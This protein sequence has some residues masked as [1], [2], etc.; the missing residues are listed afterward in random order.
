MS[1]VEGVSAEQ[2]LR[3]VTLIEDTLRELPKYADPAAAIAAGYASIGDAGTGT[4]HYIKA[5]LIEDDVLLDPTAPE[6]LVYAVNGDQRTLAGA[7]YIASPRPADDP[8]LTDWAGPLMTWHKHDNL[9]WSAGDDGKA[10][11]VGVIDANGNCA[12]GVRVRRREPDGPRL[13]RTAPV[14]CLRRARR[15][16]CRHG[17]RVG[18]AARRHVRRRPRSRRHRGDGQPRP[19]RR[20][21]TTRPC[22]ST[23]AA[24]PA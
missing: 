5:D 19:P 15:H 6:S 2:E 10:K 12:N 20:N 3:A 8:T 14:W 16:R 17:S 11:V 18:G 21:R 9:C 24:P 1:G 4:E 7:M 22:R 23:S 13:D